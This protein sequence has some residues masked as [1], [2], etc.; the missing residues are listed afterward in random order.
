M[1]TINILNFVVALALLTDLYSSNE[2][3]ECKEAKDI[4]GNNYRGTVN[5]TI[6]GLTCQKW[7]EKTP[8]NHDVNHKEY[9]DSGLGGGHNYCRGPTKSTFF[10]PDGP[11]C[12]NG[13]GK[14]PPY[15]YCDIPTCEE[16]YFQKRAIKSTSAKP[17][18]WSIA[19]TYMPT[20]RTEQSGGQL[21]RSVTRHLSYT[22][23]RPT[24]SPS[25]PA[26]TTQPRGKEGFE[27]K[28]MGVGTEIF[29]M[30]FHIFNLV[31]TAIVNPVFILIV[32]TRINLRKDP[33]VIP[34]LVA[35]IVALVNLGTNWGFYMG[36]KKGFTWLYKNNRDLCWFT[37]AVSDKISMFQVVC[38]A[39]VTL[40]AAYA[41]QY[42]MNYKR[43]SWRTFWTIIGALFVDLLLLA[44]QIY[45][46]YFWTNTPDLITSFIEKLGGESYGIFRYKD[47]VLRR[48]KTFGWH[49]YFMRCER[50][51]MPGSW[52][53]LLNI[54]L[55]LVP[56][57][58]G[59]VCM[60]YTLAQ[61][62]NPRRKRRNFIAAVSGKYNFT[63]ENLEDDENRAKSVA[64]ITMVCSIV[65]ALMYIIYF[66][67][68]LN[69]DS[70]DT[71]LYIFGVD[72]FYWFQEVLKRSCLL[73]SWLPALI[74]LFL[75]PS[76]ARAM[77]GLLRFSR[78]KEVEKT[79]SV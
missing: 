36:I 74:S 67:I 22:T 33:S 53:Y 65:P 40:E 62:F 45:F 31:L 44:A 39:I 61:A 35:C 73:T 55:G 76:I 17:T 30:V 42:P 29:F 16:S 13:E 78:K 70:E 64:L 58:W 34:L 54:L 63:V 27:K 19:T 1:V 6:S 23:H 7:D 38:Y 48:E 15:E 37:D 10:F 18:T 5:T 12:Y 24:F 25:T 32:V 52:D 68:Y 75:N 14:E 26:P 57:L 3:K 59:L 66:M 47:N 11:W 79:G 51:H 21:S 8:N 2:I 50:Y 77:M 60:T 49:F 20:G 46:Y 4:P 41:M 43:S 69:P 71:L 9:P 72:G 56:C 28:R